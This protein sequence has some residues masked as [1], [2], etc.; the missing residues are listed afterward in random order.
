MTKSATRRTFLASAAGATLAACTRDEQERAQ[1]RPNILFAIADDQS[2]PHASALG[3]KWVS[4][5]AFDRVA[6]EGAL[7]T[8][9]FAT[10]PSCTPSRTSVLSGRHIWQTGEGGV[11]YGTLPPDLPLATH[12]LEDAGYHVGYTGKP[13]QP[14][15]WKAGGLTRHPNG[16]EYNARKHSGPIPAGIDERDYAANFEDFL[17]DRPDDTP[18]FF[19]YGCTE[20]HR[21]YEDGVGVRN[22]KNLAE[23]EP[24][25]FLPDTEVV[26]SDLADYAFEIE[27]FDTQLT[28]MLARLEKAGELDNTLV[29]VTSDNGMPFPRAKVNLYDWGVRMPLAMRFPAEIP[30]GTQVDALVSHVDFAPTW[31]SVAGVEAPA[32]MAGSSLLPLPAEDAPAR[33][34]VYSGLERHTW[35]RPDGATYPARSIRTKDYLYIR[36]FEPDRW[37]TGGPD[38][39]SS[40]KTF[41]GDVDACPTKTFMVEHREEFPGEYA[42]GFGKRPSEE[43]Y[44]IADDPGQVRNLAD[45]PALA[46]QKQQLRARLEAYLRETGDPRIEG[47]DHWQSYIYRQTIGFGATFNQA[48]PEEEREAARGRGSHKPE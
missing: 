2:W 3:S 16:K 25:D 41:H 12:R 8:H 9:S 4:T 37:P 32:G 26:R 43:L 46:D 20:P 21:V 11:L 6:R 48:L 10:C 5:P 24:P 18:F 7:F 22:G 36:N 47:Q 40:N 33:G 14:G 13:W 17:A 1:R 27:W 34:Q 42:L 28:K 15:D 44:V 31:L 45:E 38:F 23:I 35:C 39:V 30:A 29:I 19:W